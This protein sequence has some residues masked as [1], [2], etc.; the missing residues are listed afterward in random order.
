MRLVENC[1]I[2]LAIELRIICQPAPRE[3]F[4]VALVVRGTISF[5]SSR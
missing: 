2:V 4:L 1:Q 5:S 3:A